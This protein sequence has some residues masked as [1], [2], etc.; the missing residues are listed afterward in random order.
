MAGYQG[1]LIVERVNQG[2]WAIC[3]RSHKGFN[4]FV[5]IR[6]IEK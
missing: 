2:D 5:S 4:W 1:G 3:W 6:Q